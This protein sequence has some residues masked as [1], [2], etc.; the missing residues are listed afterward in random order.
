MKCKCC[1]RDST[2]N[3]RFCPICGENN[4]EYVE[5]ITSNASNSNGTYVNQQIKKVPIYPSSPTSNQN[6]GNTNVLL[7]SQTNVQITDPVEGKGVAVC[8]L[9]FSILGGWL[10]LIFSIIG[11]SMYKQRTNRNLCK[12]GLFIFIGWIVLLVILALT[13]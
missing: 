3:D 12:A 9:V 4:D 2:E 8:A 5:I 11:L 7:Y 10:G 13:L 1:G 6:Q